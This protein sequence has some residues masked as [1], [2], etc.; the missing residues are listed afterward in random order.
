MPIINCKDIPAEN[1]LAEML[2]RARPI[3]MGVYQYHSRAFTPEECKVILEKQKYFD[4][5]NGCPIKTNFEKFPEL[6]SCG[7]DRDHG[8]NALQKCIDAINSKT[9]KTTPSRT[10]VTDD[11]K[12]KAL[13]NS[14]IHIQSFSD[15]RK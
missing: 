8:E 3:G 13:G 7:Y 5:F 9:V 4:Y 1:V 15:F 14:K 12:K 2:N 10:E 6:D 11:E